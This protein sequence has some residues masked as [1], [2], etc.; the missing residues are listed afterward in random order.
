M[1]EFPYTREE[2]TLF[3]ILYPTHKDF[4]ES[5]NRLFVTDRK[6]TMIKILSW[7]CYTITNFPDL[8]SYQHREEHLSIADTVYSVTL[9]LNGVEIGNAYPKVSIEVL[10]KHT[11]LNEWATSE[12]IAALEDTI[13][14]LAKKLT[15]EVE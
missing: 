12:E 10:R 5:Y 4:M 7:M 11:K 2:H 13:Y 9:F 6:G 15:R 14:Q 1:I 8:I 3:T